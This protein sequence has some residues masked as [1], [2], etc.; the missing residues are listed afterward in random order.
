MYG[1]QHIH[2]ASASLAGHALRKFWQHRD[3][4]WSIYLISAL[5][6][7]MRL[8]TG[9][10]LLSS[11]A[12]DI[13]LGLLFNIITMP[14][15]VLGLSRV[16]L[17]IMQ[18]EPVRLLMILED[19]K[20]LRSLK[21]ALAAALIW[22][23]PALLVTFLTSV[24]LPRIQ[25]LGQIFAVIPPLTFGI[26]AWIW[27]L[28]KLFMFPYLYVTH[29]KATLFKL[30]KASFEAVQGN[31]LR[32]ALTYLKSVWAVALVS[33]CMIMLAAPLVNHEASRQG[34]SWL[35]YNGAITISITILGPYTGLAMAGYAGRLMKERMQKG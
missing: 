17:N 13:L 16:L 10:Y 7:F 24:Q 19:A 31:M 2:S 8:A 9:I 4:L 11:P 1:K 20:N 5:F 27:L 21:K 33:I 28:I 6:T 29:P 25:T 26:S 30:V 14:F 32:T 23:V 12:A 22:Q 18:G 15:A 3:L 35:F 34:S